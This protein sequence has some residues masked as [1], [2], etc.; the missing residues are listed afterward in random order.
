MDRLQY[1]H[2]F[3]LNDNDSVDNHIRSKSDSQIVPFV[4]DG[5]FYLPIN[6]QAHGLKLHF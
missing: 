6:R 1:F 2:R 3:Q 5:H 4:D